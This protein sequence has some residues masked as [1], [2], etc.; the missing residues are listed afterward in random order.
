MAPVTFSGK[1]K[2]ATSTA[3]VRLP[4]RSDYH[5]RRD[6][7]QETKQIDEAKNDTTA[8]K[9]VNKQQGGVNRCCGCRKKVGLTGFRCR[10]GDMYCSEH[11]YSD[12]HDCSF[13]YKAA[14][15]ETIA[16]ENPVV[17]AA[18]IVRL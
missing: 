7:L 6:V 11:R 5:H 12:R 15:R 8:S 10:C 13:D 9:I 17:K 16:R 2:A 14:G 1:E 3:F 4:E 18:K